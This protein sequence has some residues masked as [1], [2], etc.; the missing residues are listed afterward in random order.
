ML[1]V[2]ATL[3]AIMGRIVGYRK[4]INENHNVFGSSQVAAAY[5]NLCDV[6]VESLTVNK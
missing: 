2:E 1:H 5:R 6:M 4:V 3:L